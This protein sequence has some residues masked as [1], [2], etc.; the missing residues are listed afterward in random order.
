MRNISI[1]IPSYNE[2]ESIPELFSRID[3]VAKLNL[4]NIQIVFVDDGSTDNTEEKVFS[5]FF[6]NVK[7]ISY[8]KFRRNF[9]KS[10]ALSEGVRKAKYDLILTMDADLQDQPEEIIK[11]LNKM[12]EGYDLVSGWK[13]KRLDS[14]FL[15]NIPSKIFNLVSFMNIKKI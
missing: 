4:L 15:K 10:E 5:F 11:L 2:S 7:D 3:L 9:G 1:I 8:I 12:D 13:R 6:K 14:V